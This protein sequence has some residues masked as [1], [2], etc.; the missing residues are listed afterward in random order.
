MKSSVSKLT[1]NDTAVMD[2]EKFFL[3]S[4]ATMPIFT[5]EGQYKL[6]QNF[7]EYLA[8]L[9]CPFLTEDERVCYLIKR[10]F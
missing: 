7:F 9:N 10:N 2:P 4:E 6:K 1:V 5:Q 3:K 8:N